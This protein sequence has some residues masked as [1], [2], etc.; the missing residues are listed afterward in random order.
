MFPAGFALGE[1]LV[2]TL[3]GIYS[4]VSLEILQQ[5]YNVVAIVQRLCDYY[6]GLSPLSLINPLA[7]QE[8][9]SSYSIM[10]SSRLCFMFGILKCLVILNYWIFLFRIH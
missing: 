8:L 5:L 7:I 2:I 10:F 1:H 3:R 6:L 9:K 4:N